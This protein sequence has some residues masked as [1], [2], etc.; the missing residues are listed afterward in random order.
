MATLLRTLL[1][2]VKLDTPATQPKLGVLYDTP[3]L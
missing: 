3:R 2:L 1:R